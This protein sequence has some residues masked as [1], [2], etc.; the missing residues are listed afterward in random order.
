MQAL[1][2]GAGVLGLGVVLVGLARLVGALR[3]GAEMGDLPATPLERL[4]LVGLAVTGALGLA[5]V[6]LVLARGAEGF[7]QDGGT[8]SIFNL[9]MLVGVVVWVAAWRRLRAPSG[10]TVIDERDRGIQARSFAVESVLVIVSLVAWTVIL[11]EVFRDEG[12]VPLGYLQLIFWSTFILGAFGRSLGIVLGY[13]Q[14]P[15]IDA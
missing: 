5:M 4:G 8:S 11:T 2:I 7:A 1:W 15:S 13:R 14:E 6:G 9:L 10:S 3:P 12:A